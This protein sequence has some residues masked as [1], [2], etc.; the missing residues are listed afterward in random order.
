MEICS[1]GRGDAGLAPLVLCGVR[2][3]VSWPA[4]T[5]SAQN[6]HTALLSSWE[7]P[8]SVCERNNEGEWRAQEGEAEVTAR[9]E[10]RMQVCRELSFTGSAAHKKASFTLP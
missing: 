2:S 3:R 10:R 7:G 9:R 4:S 8:Q 1:S 5:H 6:N